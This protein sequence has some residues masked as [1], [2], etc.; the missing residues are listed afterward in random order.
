MT[1]VTMYSERNV[2]TH[3][4][5]T[6]FDLLNKNTNK[7]TFFNCYSLS[8]II[9]KSLFSQLFIKLIFWCDVR[10]RY[11][12]NTRIIRKMI[13]TIIHGCSTC[14]FSSIQLKNCLIIFIARKR[15][16]KCWNALIVFRY[17]KIQY[18]VI[19]IWIENFIAVILK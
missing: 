14:S 7:M 8:S 11:T 16:Q 5:C 15:G 6:R 18:T 12:L 3:A 1:M 17:W 13:V 4:K 10:F 9:V 19:P 2:N